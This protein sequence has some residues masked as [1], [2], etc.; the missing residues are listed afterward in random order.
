MQIDVSLTTTPKAKPG[1]DAALGFG[2]HFTDHMFMMEYDEGKGW[3]SP[4]IEPYH[5]L[6]LDPASSVLHYA[7]EIFEGL[8]AYH[9][10][11][12]RTLLFRARDNCRRL[13]RSASRLYMPEIDV[14]FNYEAIRRLVQTEREWIPEKPGES[15]YIRPTMIANDEALGV[16]EAAHYLYYIICSPSG[17]YYPT[18][19][20]PIR[21][22]VEDKYIRAAPGGMG[23][24]KTGGNYACS[25]RAGAE[26]AKLGFSQVLWLDGRER[27]YVQE[28][29]AMNM[30][31]V[32]NGK[33][34]TAPLEDT[35]LP[36]ITRDSILTLAREKGLTIEERPISI[37]ELIE[38][39]R[40]GD[41]K[42]A[43]G[44]GTA[45][46]V[47]PVKELTYRDIAVTIGGGGIGPMTQEFYDTLTGL[48][49]GRIQDTRGWVTEV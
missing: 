31:F 9:S 23:G 13:N 12:G 28:V 15:L 47:S 14:E 20:A 36:G 48:Q 37:E 19:I 30:M 21:I 40:S 27:R 4:R 22:L 49:W 8:K 6:S 24:A 10:A 29:G 17:S 16:H 3:H 1:E 41:L 11:D 44:T 43:F 45:A 38:S 42:E 35:I 18:G 5:R 25:I 33:L 2:K 34:V 46:V 7:Q 26:A 32:I 39:G